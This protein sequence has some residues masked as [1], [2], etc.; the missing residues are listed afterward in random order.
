MSALNHPDYENESKRL[1]L[2]IDY[3]KHFDEIIN[4]RKKQID[5]YLDYSKTH[6]NSDNSEQFNELIINET[7]QGSMESRLKNISKSLNKPYFARVDFREDGANKLGRYYIGKMSLLN[8]DTE[9]FLIIDW[10]SPIANLYYEGRLGESSYKCPDGEISGKISLKRQYTIENAKLEEIFD[11]DI[12]TNDDFLQAAL[13]SN[14]DNRLKDIVSTIQTEQNKVIRA[15][16]WN[17]LIVQ[18]AA[19]GGKT[20]IALHRIAYL[21]YHYEKTLKPE[22]F[23]IIAPNSFFLSYISEV[24]PELGVENV[25]QTTFEDFAFKVLGKNIGKKLKL[26]SPHEK[27]STII[28]NSPNYMNNNDNTHADII[29]MASSFK[30][31]LEFKSLLSRYLIYIEYHYIPKEDFKVNEFVLFTYKEIQRQFIKEYSYLPFTKRINEIKKRMLNKISYQ[32]D[33]ILNRIED[34]YEEKLNKVRNAMDDCEERRI[35]IISI[36]DE[37][38][39]LLSDIKSGLKNVVKDYISKIPKRSIY[40]YYKNFLGN[41]DKL[42][43]DNHDIDIINYIKDSSLENLKNNTIEIEDLSPLMDIATSI[44][45][46]NEK[47]NLRHIVIDEA[48]DLSLFQFYILKKIVN[49]NSFTILGDL[50][51]GI[52]SYRGINDWNDVSTHIFD[53]NSTKLCLEQSYRTTIEIMNSATKV[54]G[55]L[56]D[57]R[58]PKAK[59][60]IRHGEEVK[61][62]EKN[63]LKEIAKEIDIRIE[64]LANSNYK[65]MAIICKTLDE[66]KKLKSLIKNKKNISLITGKEKNYPGGI[67]IIPCHLAKGLEFDVV[68]IANVS[69]EAYIKKE[70]DVKL[71]YVAMTRPLHELY[72]YSLGEKSEILP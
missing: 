10:R 15:P 30:S 54:I 40:I 31:S 47:I 4:K 37:R 56:S 55:S 43:G 26:N 51:Q 23:M 64:N 66:C 38:D 52:Y 70:L 46:I 3:L 68:I 62:F 58:L 69:K 57:S 34:E 32:S 59:P 28:E 22:N 33:K 44:Y 63:S 21:M 41:L 11:I 36:I 61:I 29:T 14:K 1:S 48:Q 2:T 8:E 20:T 50:C 27:L 12:T 7:L 65:S 9:E 18:G 45:G 25:I 35:K 19:G 16:M 72:I 24:L 13:G 49:N 6:Y 42:K 67:V 53:E 39:N 71:L 5:E 60:V 17:P